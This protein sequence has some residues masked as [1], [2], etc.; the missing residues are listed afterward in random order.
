MKNKIKII[1]L[2]VFVITDFYTLNAQDKYLKGYIIKNQDTVH[3]YIK[4]A[5][6]FEMESV[7]SVK[8]N[9]EDR[10]FTN[11]KPSQI[12]GFY[13][14]NFGYFSSENFTYRRV[15]DIMK[16]GSLSDAEVPVFYKSTSF[17]RMPV[18]GE[19][20]LFIFIDSKQKKH[21]FIKKDTL[22]KE[23][24][25]KKKFATKTVNNKKVTGLVTQKKYIGVLI[26]FF[27]DCP[28]VKNKLIH[29]ELR[30]SDLIKITNQYNK[31]KNPGKYQ[32][33]KVIKNKKL[34]F[35]KSF[36]AGGISNQY[37][38][39]GINHDW[40]LRSQY[41]TPLT[42]TF[43]ANFDFIFP[44]LSYDLCVSTGLSYY[45]SPYIFQYDTIISF[46]NYHYEGDM[47]T[48]YL[49]IPV[50]GKYTFR[51]NKLQPYFFAGLFF[52][53]VLDNKNTL[54]IHKYND[55]KDI[56]E[57]QFLFDYTDGTTGEYKSA[58]RPIENGYSLG[59]GIKFKISDKLAVY[60][61][62]KL[63]KGSGYSSLTTFGFKSTY[64]HFI[65]GIEF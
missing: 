32:E 1:V 4:K 24:Y 56:T 44:E 22:F 36:F 15:N 14:Q 64:M 53:I 42:Y 65:A 63:D 6:A 52:N 40:L 21:F 31:C 9:P 55:F 57:S 54:T 26:T 51:K 60:S 35:K 37:K 28:E 48:H 16:S 12:D 5:S 20:S 62:F 43:G 3:C 30:E 8:T 39:N 58:L 11:Y 59:G 17:L 41:K 13:T 38:M 10:D 50:L 45:H 47:S 2:I 33:N 29:T 61:E 19:V 46:V 34:I 7:I 18:S 27:Y 49:K 25:V 23:L